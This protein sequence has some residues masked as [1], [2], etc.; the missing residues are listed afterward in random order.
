MY[1]AKLHC[2]VLPGI[3]A[4]LLAVLLPKPRTASAKTRERMRLLGQSYA[5][6]VR[7]VFSAGTQCLKPGLISKLDARMPLVAA[8]IDE[9]FRI[10]SK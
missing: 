9:L 3:C 5:V 8:D 2:T 7:R 6:L 10:I 1:V 4:A